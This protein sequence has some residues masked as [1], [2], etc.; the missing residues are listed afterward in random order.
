[1]LHPSSTPGVAREKE[2]TRN[3]ERKNHQREGEKVT[4]SNQK[5]MHLVLLLALDLHHTPASQ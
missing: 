1:M 2:D 3:E 4:F 5:K